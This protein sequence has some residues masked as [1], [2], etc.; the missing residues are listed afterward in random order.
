MI[1]KIDATKKRFEN[2]DSTESRLFFC[3]PRKLGKIIT[4][5]IWG[6]GFVT[7]LNTKDEEKLDLPYF[8]YKHIYISGISTIII[9]DVIGGNFKLYPYKNTK[10]SGFI[11]LSE[12]EQ[13]MFKR[14]WSYDEFLN[15]YV[16]SLEGGLDWPYGFY[17]LNI[18]TNGK[19]SIEFDT[20]DCIDLEKYVRNT[21]KYGF[22]L[23]KV[24]EFI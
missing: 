16:Y 9:E 22:N 17:E 11:K 3:C 10:G 8:P 14:K 24:K 1:Y 20:D 23:E 21:Q 18:M 5:K 2:I 19:V 4:L 15:P 13:E 7:F 12:E 6:L